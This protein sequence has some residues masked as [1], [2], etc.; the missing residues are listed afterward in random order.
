MNTRPALTLS[1]LLATGAAT[2]ADLQVIVATASGRPAAE[3]VVMVVPAAGTPAPAP[4]G[5]TIVQRDNRFEP[6][7]TAIPAG[8]RVLFSNRDRY[9]HHVRSLGSGP[10]GAVPPAKSFE[11]RLGGVQAGVKASTAEVM[12]DSPGSVV[13]GCHIHG[14]MRG[15]LFIATTPWVAVTDDFG[16]ATLRGLPDGAAEL[17]LWHPDQLAAQAT[18]T[19]RLQGSSTS[20]ATLGFTPQRRPAPRPQGDYY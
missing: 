6:Y 17:R 11:L 1:I 12:F 16:R 20:N 14:S 7:V 2:A 13:L 5:I 3:V 19:L 4:D 8:T 15:H 9:D 18:Q 10:M